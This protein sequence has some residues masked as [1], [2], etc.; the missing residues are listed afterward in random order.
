MNLSGTIVNRRYLTI[1]ILLFLIGSGFSCTSIAYDG[2][3]YDEATITLEQLKSIFRECQD[4]P[5]D[6]HVSIAL[7]EYGNIKYYGI[8]RENDTIFTSINPGSVFEIGSISKVFT[9]TLLADLVVQGKVGLDDQVSDYL[10][11]SFKD[12][13]SITFKQLA[14]HTSGLPRLPSNLKLLEVDFKNPYKDY[15]EAKLVEYLTQELEVEHQG[16]FAYSNLGVGL[17]GFTLAKI[18]KTTYEDL[19]QSRIF[20]RYQMTSSTTDRNLVKNILV[21]GL[22]RKG[23]ETPNWDPNVL[24]GAGGILSSVGDLSKF[25]LAQFDDSNEVLALT[26]KQTYQGYHRG[27][28]ITGI[29]LGWMIRDN[30][31]KEWY[32]HNG[33]T[34]GYTS[35]MQIDVEKKNAVIILTNISA[36]NPKR[37]NID[38]LGRRLMKSF[39]DYNS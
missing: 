17:L 8:K 26:R 23:L 31:G 5:N 10:N 1:L 14:N 36:F 28:A 27:G 18:E 21:P 7:I 9:S 29:G 19:L 16:S 3:D 33:G 35:F 30:Q 38:S 6:T 32:W 22:N 20:S 34:G 39:Y 12:S 4:L 11:I 25:A 2:Q 15:D 37:A 24:V 13:P